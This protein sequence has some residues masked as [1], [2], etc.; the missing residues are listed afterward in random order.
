[1]KNKKILVI[2]PH[3]DDESLGAGGTIAKF[4]SDNEISVLTVAGHRPPLYQEKDY[5]K[6]VEEANKA[7]KILGIHESIFLDI[8]TTTIGSMALHEFYKMVIDVVSRIEPEIVLIPYYDRH[9]DHREVFEA[10]MIATRPVR[11]GQ[12]IKLIAAYETPSSTHWN[13]PYIEPT[14]TPNWVVDI[15]ESI[16]R[17]LEA[18][19]CYGSQIPPFPGPR[20]VEALKGLA[21]FRGTQAGFGYGEAFLIIRQIS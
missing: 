8:P 19:A 12:K 11:H 5:E 6:T 7:H 4:S 21:I 14:F 9:I 10:A 2:S 13:A 20:S 3:P 1:M 16:D 17:K 15:E 18:I